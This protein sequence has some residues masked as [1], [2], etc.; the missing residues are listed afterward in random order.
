MGLTYENSPTVIIEIYYKH[1]MNILI[2]TRFEGKTE[3]IH[4]ITVNYV[5]VKKGDVHWKI[6]VWRKVWYTRLMGFIEGRENNP[7]I[8][9]VGL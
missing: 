6:S 7:S 8:I 9:Y 1:Y 2:S 5:T 3:G 4:R